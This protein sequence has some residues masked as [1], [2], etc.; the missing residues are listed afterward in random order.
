M[1]VRTAII[2]IGVVL[3]RNGGVVSRL[4]T[5]F[6]F[7]AGGHPGS[8]KQWVSWIHLED[9]IGVI[10]ML[11]EDESC[12][13]TFNLTAPEPVLSKKFYGT[14]GKTMHRPSVFPMPP[15]MLR[16]MLGEIADELLLTSNRVI[17]QRL[18]EAGYKYRFPNLSEALRNILK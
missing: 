2:R 9:V 7:F 11:I 14:F 6:R 15:F 1:G 13:G 3:G 8:G 4:V 18:L 16:L 10:R 12:K 5:P 17:P